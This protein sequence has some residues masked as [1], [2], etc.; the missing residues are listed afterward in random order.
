M[1]LE[2]QQSSPSASH[3]QYVK[4][5]ICFAACFFPHFVVCSMPTRELILGK[6]FLYMYNCGYPY[7]QGSLSK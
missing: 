5:N 3:R 1:D 2:M 4:S 7:A 6:V